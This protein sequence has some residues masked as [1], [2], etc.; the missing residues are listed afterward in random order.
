[1]AWLGLPTAG[2]A[3][4][5]APHDLSLDQ[6]PRTAR[7]TNPTFLQ[8]TNDVAVA[9]SSV[10]A[11]YGEL[12]PSLTA[13]NSYGCTTAGEAR[14][15][16]IEFGRQTESYSSSYS[17]KMGLNLS[18]STL[19]QPYV[20][21]AQKRTTER[22]VEGAAATLDAQVTQQY[23]TV[24]QAR[25]L[26]AQA[27]RGGARTAEH[28]RLAEARLEVVAGTPLDVQR[29]QAQHGQSEVNLV[30]A[31]NTADVEAITL[32]RLLGTPLDPE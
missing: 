30:H 8:Q 17:L 31:R 10:R 26:V 27:E 20:Q 18:G 21:R 22:Q 32:G 16:T 29:A 14:Y 7:E 24:L 23:L 12:L 19:L 4:P 28:V 2:A 5:P 1:M 25:E 6:A 15:N 13:S 11:A 3:Q 9:R